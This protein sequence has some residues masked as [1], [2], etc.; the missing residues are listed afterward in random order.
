M[1]HSLHARARH[2]PIRRAVTK[3]KHVNC[4]KHHNDGET[5]TIQG[6]V[7]QLA[8]RTRKAGSALR[9]SSRATVLLDNHS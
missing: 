5:L 4:A 3:E 8:S 6:V 1:L 2:S 9:K 7:L